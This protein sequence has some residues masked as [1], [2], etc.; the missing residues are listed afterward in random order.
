VARLA[1]LAPAVDG[2]PEEGEVTLTD[3]RTGERTIVR[4]GDIVEAR[5]EIEL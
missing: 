4:L 5:L 1:G 3:E 2:R